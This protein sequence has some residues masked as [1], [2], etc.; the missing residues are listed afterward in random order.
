MNLFQNDFSAAGSAALMV[1]TGDDNTIN[2]SQDGSDNQASLS[3][4]G[5]GNEMNI[6]QENTGN[7]LS[8]SQIG[9]G[10]SGAQVVQGGNQVIEITQS[11]TG[12]A[13]APPP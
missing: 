1:Q 5:T 4:D 7:R 13:F 12:S 9:E 6:I 8:W 11:N 3:Q 10:L 2:L